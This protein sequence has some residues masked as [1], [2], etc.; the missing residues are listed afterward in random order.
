MK[1]LLIILSIGFFFS[2]ESNSIEKKAIEIKINVDS[3]REF[4]IEDNMKDVLILTKENNPY[5]SDV[6]SSLFAINDGYIVYDVNQMM[7]KF[8]SKGKF[9]TSTP[10]EFYVD[11][12]MKADSTFIFDSDES[13]ILVYDR[14]GNFINKK[15]TKQKNEFNYL[16]SFQNQYI[17]GKSYQIN[18]TKTGLSKSEFALYDSN[19]EYIA[20]IDT[21]IGSNLMLSTTASNGEILAVDLYTLDIFSI[22]KEKRYFEKKYTINFHEYSLPPNYI[23]KDNIMEIV[24]TKR[25]NYVSGIFVMSESDNYLVF[26]YLLGDKIRFAIYDKNNNKA[27]SFLITNSSLSSNKFLSSDFMVRNLTVNDDII[28]FYLQ[29]SKMLLYQ[30]LKLK[31]L[32]C[33]V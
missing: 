16:F 13:Q 2:C 18:D 22:G 10:Y 5:L 3:S 6:P 8:D 14:N 32:F 17:G 19:F 7:T 31:I 24:N 11:L 23:T 26:H 30:K 21:P 1:N 12:N 15:S 27:H 33:K 4:K 25:E 29:S 28:M 9:V 20:D